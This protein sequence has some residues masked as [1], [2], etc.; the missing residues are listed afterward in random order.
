[1]AAI[2]LCEGLLAGCVDPA[3]AALRADGHDAVVVDPFTSTDPLAYTFAAL[4]DAVAGATVGRPAVALGASLGA[5]AA[6]AFARHH[7]DRCQAL[8]LFQPVFLY[9]TRDELRE[10]AGVAR[11]V[12]AVAPVWQRLFG[13]DARLPDHDDAVVL[14]ALDGLGN[15]VLIH[16]PDDLAAV[17]QPTLLVARAGDALHAME[18]ATA[19]WR[20]IPTTRMVNEVPGDVPFWDRPA[21]LAALVDRF[22]AEVLP[23]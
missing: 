17:T 15:D 8:I 22:L 3:A 23:H 12:G 19:Y 1:V 13:G 5:G 11:Q 21:D 20:H 16:G 6:L 4:A 18:V 2:V 7:P 10:I 9:G 14:A